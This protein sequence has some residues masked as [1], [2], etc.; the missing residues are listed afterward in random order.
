ML[1]GLSPDL[2]KRVIALIEGGMSRRAAASQMKVAVSSAIRWFK[3]YQTTGSFAEKPGKRAQYSP[4]E[5]HSAWLL[6]LVR[7][8]PD[9]TLAQIVVRLHD[10]HDLKITDSSVA[11]FFQR[12]HISYKKNTARQPTAPRRRG[13]GPRGMEGDA[14]VT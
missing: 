11:R 2:R 3:L 12:H 14:A 13:E 6:A 5:A 7:S 9:L 4:L 1:R 8:E 10:K